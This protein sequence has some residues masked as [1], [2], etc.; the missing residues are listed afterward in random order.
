[1]R[2]SCISE[3]QRNETSWLTSILPSQMTWP[4][5][6]T[7]SVVMRKADALPAASMTTST[8]RPPVSRLPAV[9]A[10]SLDA[11]TPMVAPR[12]RARSSFAGS[13][14]TAM[15]LPALYRGKADRPAADYHYGVAVGDGVKIER[16]ADTG[17]HAA[18]DQAGAIKGN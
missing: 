17:H 12:R 16:G 15:M 13:I 14:S 9:T 5:G 1:M 18:A 8:P 11:F 10:S 3:P 4:P 6:R 2:F 7:A